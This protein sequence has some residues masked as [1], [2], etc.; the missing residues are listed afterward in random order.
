MTQIDCG[1]A[2]PR[3]RPPVQRALQRAL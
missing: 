1:A 3:A 2:W